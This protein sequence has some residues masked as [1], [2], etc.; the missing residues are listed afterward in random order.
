MSP[1]SL[2]WKESF[3]G[4]FCQYSQ[5]V[6]FSSILLFMETVGMVIQLWVWKL[7][8]LL[9]LMCAPFMDTMS[10]IRVIGK[11]PGIGL[12]TWLTLRTTKKSFPIS[13]LGR[14][15]LKLHICDD[16]IEYLVRFEEED[17][18]AR[19][20]LY[21]LTFNIGNTIYTPGSSQKQVW[22]ALRRWVDGKP[23]Q[24]WQNQGY[25]M[26]WRPSAECFVQSLSTKK[27]TS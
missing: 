24:S 20:L 15:S 13:E 27:W 5:M 6:V 9:C 18:D 21:S 2:H 1:A 4:C 19:S 25:M 23:F 11:H 16:P 17:W 10:M 8:R 12:A 14:S 22:V 3:Q 26:T 7:G